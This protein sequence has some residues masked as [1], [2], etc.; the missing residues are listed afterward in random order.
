MKVGQIELWK[1]TDLLTRDNST[2]LYVRL[3]VQG[4]LNLML[5]PSTK[6]A[7]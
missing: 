1:K 3:L 6:G 4:K 2:T 5:F 7:F